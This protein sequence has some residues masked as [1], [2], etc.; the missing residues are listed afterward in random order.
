MRVIGIDPGTLSFDICGLED[1]IVFLDQSVASADL[2]RGAAPLV[3]VLNASGP[4]DLA[5]GPSG[6][7]LP[8]VRAEDVGEREMALMLL[9]RQDETP[10]QV[11][12]GGMKG[13]IRALI[14]TGIPFVFAP[15]A[16]HLPT[17]PAYRKAN[18]IDMGTADTRHFRSS[19]AL[20]P[21]V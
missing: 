20:Q 17:I 19:A 7:G 6:Y 14:A 3:D 4:I 1:G 21:C 12:I 13:V 16:I 10:A 11:G 2:D 15:G 9:V 8:W 5:L 18:R